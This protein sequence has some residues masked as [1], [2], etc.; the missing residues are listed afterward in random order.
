MFLLEGA[1]NKRILHVSRLHVATLND[2]LDICI[3]V[4]II[5]LL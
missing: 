5:Y 1:L 2:C 3:C 4:L